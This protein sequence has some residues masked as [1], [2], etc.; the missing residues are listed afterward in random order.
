MRKLLMKGLVVGAITAMA[1]SAIAFAAVIGSGVV[2]ADALRM[3]SEPSTGSKTITY[4]TDGTKVQVHE[5]LTDWY[6][7]SYGVY[8]GYVH[9]DYLEYTPA[10]A[11]ELQ[12]PPTAQET[13]EEGKPAVITG[14]DVNFRAEASTGSKVLAVLKKD[15]EVRLLSVEDDWC[16]V[17][18]EKQT[19]Y[20][21]AAYVAVDGLP[22]VDAD[23]GKE[24]G[25]LK[26]VNN[27]AAG[28]LYEIETENGMVL[29]PVVPQFVKEVDPD[30]GI[31][32]TP[33][34]GFF[35]EI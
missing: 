5:E 19:G 20:V 25:I 35:D 3:R 22:V 13:V 1:L 4:L 29:L 24:Y 17:V 21:S 26:N 33:I 11:A 7:V 9:A 23:S 30:K 14:N 12:L 2:D 31:F 15:A 34:P 6:K 28:Q 18:W 8:T 27:G 16:R 32:V 10:P